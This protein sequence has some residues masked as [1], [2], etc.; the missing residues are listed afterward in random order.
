MNYSSWLWPSI[1]YFSL[2]SLT[3]STLKTNFNALQSHANGLKIAWKSFKGNYLEL[4]RKFGKSKAT[5]KSFSRSLQRKWESTKE[6]LFGKGLRKRKQGPHSFFNF[7][8]E[9]LETDIMLLGRHTVF[10]FGYFLF[11]LRLRDWDMKN[12]T[13]RLSPP[14]SFL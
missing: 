11:I 4:R 5:L 14:K 13:V 10:S 9:E 12:K 2:V 6:K 8:R 7:A 3:D 1:V